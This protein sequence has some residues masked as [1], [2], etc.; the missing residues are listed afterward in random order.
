MIRLKTTWVIFVTQTYR[1]TRRTSSGKQNAVV[2]KVHGLTRAYHAF[3]M[4]VNGNIISYMKIHAHYGGTVYTA[5]CKKKYTQMSKIIL[6]F[7]K[8]I[9]MWCHDPFTKKKLKIIFWHL[10]T[11]FCNRLNATATQAAGRRTSDVLNMMVNRLKWIIMRVM[12]ITIV[13]LFSS[14][15]YPQPGTIRFHRHIRTTNMS[16]AYF[17]KWSAHP[18]TSVQMRNYRK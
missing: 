7:I 15:S 5:S 18:N 2:L 6:D 3:I 12:I 4:P 1:H 8:T 14:W 11:D 9:V 13:L 17:Q 10:Y 16:T